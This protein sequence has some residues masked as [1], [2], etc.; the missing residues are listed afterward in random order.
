MF[1]EHANLSQTV[2]ILYN[3]NIIYFLSKN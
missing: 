2:D 1:L 3:E